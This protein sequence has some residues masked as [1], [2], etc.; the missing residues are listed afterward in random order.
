MG[1]SKPGEVR[2]NR[3]YV[4]LNKSELLGVGFKSDNRKGSGRGTFDGKTLADEIKALRG[5]HHVTVLVKQ[6]PDSQA[7][8][9]YCVVT[10]LEVDQFAK[11]ARMGADYTISY[12]QLKKHTNLKFVPV[13][14][15]AQQL[16]D[17]Y[18]KYN[19]FATRARERRGRVVD[20]SPRRPQY[21]KDFLVAT[22]GTDDARGKNLVGRAEEERLWALAGYCVRSFPGAGKAQ[23]E[24]TYKY[25]FQARKLGRTVRIGCYVSTVNS[26]KPEE[27]EPTKLANRIE[28]GDGFVATLASTA[29]R[30]VRDTHSAPHH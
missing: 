15:A 22:A 23:F 9:E 20:T 14:D 27:W 5:G 2:Q 4:L 28:S 10:P 25:L 8:P 1:P 11:V 7:P 19:R 18:E 30:R 13:A 21:F 3:S 6:T 29:P 16:V 24:I 17:A 26:M 12:Y